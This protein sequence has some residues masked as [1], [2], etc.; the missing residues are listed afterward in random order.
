MLHLLRGGQPRT[1]NLSPELVLASSSSSSIAEC[2]QTSCQ[3]EALFKTE[4]DLKI[5]PNC[6]CDQRYYLTYSCLLIS[7]YIFSYFLFLYHSQV[8]YI[9]MLSQVPTYLDYLD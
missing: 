2:L 4:V 8:I 1:L 5:T 6:G 9:Q 7:L 3:V